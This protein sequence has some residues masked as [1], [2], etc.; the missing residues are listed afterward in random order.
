M[1]VCSVSPTHLRMYYYTI[2]RS[3][4]ALVSDSTRE[5]SIMWG[6][7]RG[8]DSGDDD[9]PPRPYV[10]HWKDDTKHLG[11]LCS[12]GTRTMRSSR[13]VGDEV[14]TAI[15]YPA[16]I[17]PL[18]WAGCEVVHPFIGQRIHKPRD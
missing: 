16:F 4:I 7:P 13:G 8:G 6:P 17:E 18:S 14:A 2:L 10:V 3:Y 1:I 11:R 9:C 15:S 5:L 12:P